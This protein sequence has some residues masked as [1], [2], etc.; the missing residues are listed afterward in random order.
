[1]KESQ[2]MGIRYLDQLFQGLAILCGTRPAEFGEEISLRNFQFKLWL[3]T[4]KWPADC[5]EQS[6][7]LFAAVKITDTMRA[8]PVDLLRSRGYKSTPSSVLIDSI[9]EHRILINNTFY[10]RELISIPSYRDYETIIENSEYDRRV[11]DDLNALT[12]WRMRIAA[13][14]GY[15]PTD[16]RGWQAYEALEDIKVGRT[17]RNKLRSE[18]TEREA[19]IPYLLVAECIFPELLTIESRL[20]DEISRSD[21]G[22]I[23]EKWRRYIEGVV[24]VMQQ[25]G[26]G[27]YDRLGQATGLTAKAWTS[28][29]RLTRQEL[30]IAGIKPDG[31]RNAPQTKKLVRQKPKITT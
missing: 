4:D 23:A 10:S 21:D 18:L 9:R 15:K 24:Y 17:K 7:K 19:R 31:R 28:F 8:D 20:E 3:R 11:I 2:I 22:A 29:E 5:F 25:L 6:G 30:D 26:E 16:N 14:K 1:M 27:E 13:T 12:R